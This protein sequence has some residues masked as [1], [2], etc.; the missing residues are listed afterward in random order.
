MYL[1]NIM[2]RKR[3]T[4]HI[5]CKKQARKNCI[6]KDDSISSKPVEIKEVI[7]I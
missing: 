5:Q 7:S 3:R 1:I 4:E 6:L 2:L